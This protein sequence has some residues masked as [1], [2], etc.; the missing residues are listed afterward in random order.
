MGEL[1]QYTLG[2][3]HLHIKELAAGTDVNSEEFL[4]SFFV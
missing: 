3:G 2:S 4:T 1:K